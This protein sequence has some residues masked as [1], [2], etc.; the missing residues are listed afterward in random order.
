MNAD[1]DLEIQ[2]KNS[3]LTVWGNP[4]DSMNFLKPLEG[5]MTTN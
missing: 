4:S 5:L 3:N 2:N 1:A